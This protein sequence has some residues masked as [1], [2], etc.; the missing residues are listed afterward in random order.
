MTT[1]DSLLEARGVTKHFTLRAPGLFGKRR[2]TVQALTDV[3]IDVGQ[4]ETLAIVGESGCGKTTL[5]RVLTMLHRADAGSVKFGGAEIRSLSGAPLMA[6]RKRIQMVFQDPFSSLNPRLTVREIIAEPLVIHALGNKSK[7]RERTDEVA[8]AVGIRAADLDRYPHQ[9]SGGQRQR[10]AIARA[11]AP[12][13]DLIVADEPLSALDVSI[14]S[15][16]INL[17][18]ELAAKHRLAYLFIS[19]DLEVVHYLADRVAVM[20]LGRVVETGSADSLFSDPRHPYTR[21]LL[22]AAPQTGRGKRAGTP[23]LSGDVASPLNPPSGCAFHPR[24]PMA[25]GLCRSA[26]PG[27][28]VIAGPKS[29]HRA[30]CH[31]KDG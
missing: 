15:Q 12:A 10:I 4:G 22:A 23:A 16:I 3:D 25:T 26:R 5:A 13:P 27:L 18:E 6:V 14:Q 28:E 8:E 7:R 20:Y 29:S 19:H 31:F 21:A 1:R 9:F 30:A 11:L 24:C 17:M 2:G